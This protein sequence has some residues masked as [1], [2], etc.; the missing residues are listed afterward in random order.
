MTATSMATARERRK[1]R[2]ESRI[3]MTRTRTMIDGGRT[4]RMTSAKI[5]VGI[6]I[7][8][9]IARL[10]TWSV[11]PPTTAARKPSDMPIENDRRLAVS[12]TPMVRDAP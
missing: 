6:A 8:V 4:E 2:V 10:S 5:R 12:A 11:Q 3:A 1:T 7:S 9:S